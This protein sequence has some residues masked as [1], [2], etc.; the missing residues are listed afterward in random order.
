M[1]GVGDKFQRIMKKNAVAIMMMVV[2]ALAT[3]ISASA[4]GV[5]RTNTDQLSLKQVK[6]INQGKTF[7]YHDDGHHNDK[8]EF[9]HQILFRINGGMNLIQG[10]FYP[11]VGGGLLYETCHFLMGVKGSYTRMSFT[12]ESSE[13]GRYNTY[14]AMAIGGWKVVQ[15]KNF[16]HY[17]A[18]Y[19]AVGYAGHQSDSDQ[20]AQTFS[21][22]AGLCAEAGIEGS[23]QL[24][25]WLNA[26]ASVGYIH[27]PSIRH[28]VGRQEWSTSGFT[29]SV[30]L[31]F[32]ISPR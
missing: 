23:V 5:Y 26:F 27:M 24:C 21:K 20:N 17:L 29:A 11:V 16:R 9:G 30:G 25:K 6:A 3:S 14:T 7:T 22:N 2:V 31:T 1:L 19:V 4:Q 10:N 12:S 15:D 18:P 28:S 13:P 8:G 32:S